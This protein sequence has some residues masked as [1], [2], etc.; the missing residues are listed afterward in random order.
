MQAFSG[1]ASSPASIALTILTGALL[2]AAA[3]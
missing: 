2:Q 1:P 3:L